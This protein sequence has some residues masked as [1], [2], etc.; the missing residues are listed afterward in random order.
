MDRP[1][2]SRLPPKRLCH[3]PYV[4]T[5]SEGFPGLKSEGVNV[6]PRIGQTPRMLNAA[7]ETLSTNSWTGSTAPTIVLLRQL[8]SANWPTSF[9]CWFQFKKIGAETNPASSGALGSITATWTKLEGCGY[10]R[11]RKTAAS[12]KPKT[13]QVAAMPKPTMK[14]AAA[15]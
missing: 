3:S 15:L 6:R 14:M 8:L 11:A 10:G 9:A 2:T 13:T 7:S 12:A 4:G 5:T 1:S